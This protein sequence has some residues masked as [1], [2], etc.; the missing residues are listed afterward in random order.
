MQVARIGLL[1]GV[2]FAVGLFGAGCSGEDTGRDACGTDNDCR[3]VDVCD[4]GSCVA[5]RFGVGGG[6]SGGGGC[7]AQGAECS[8]HAECCGF[9]ASVFPTAACGGVCVTACTEASQC[10]TGCCAGPPGEVGVCLPADQCG[11]A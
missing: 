7:V 10:S 3:G 11:G 5:P 2:L 6:P 8:A 4:N 9:D 1:L